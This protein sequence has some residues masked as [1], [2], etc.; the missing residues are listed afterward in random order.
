MN[1]E[2][3]DQKGKP[4]AA[5][6]AEVSDTVFG[7]KPNAK[8]ISQYVFMYLSNQREGNSS[9]KDRSEVRGGGKKPWRQKGTGRARFGSSRV[10]IWRGGGIVFGPT[11]QRNWKKQITKS[12]KKAALRNILSSLVVDKKIK[13]VDSLDLSAKDKLTKSVADFM[14]KF[15]KDFRSVLF[16][17]NEMNADLVKGVSNLQNVKVTFLGEVSPYE[18]YTAKSIVF[19]KEAIE[20]L[21]KRLDK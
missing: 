2:I 12:F 8:V 15:D 14:N 6:K 18:L 11:P 16:V 3:L 1:I 13:V 17:T 21:S 4:L 7:L 20:N 9:T 10:P 5:K 19:E